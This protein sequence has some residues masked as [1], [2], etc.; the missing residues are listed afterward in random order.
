MEHTRPA[1]PFPLFVRVARALGLGR[2]RFRRR[3]AG[4]P[5]RQL[6]EL[7]SMEDCGSCRRVRQVLTELDIDYVHRSCPVGDE[8]TRAELRARGGKAQV[9]FLVDPNH[10]VEMYESRDIVHHLLAHYG[11]GA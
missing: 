11:V 1:E 4:A 5:P 7:Y 10:A 6:L 9:P 2:G 8:T 3:D